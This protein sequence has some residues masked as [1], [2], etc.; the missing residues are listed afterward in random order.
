MPEMDG[1][2]TLKAMRKLEDYP[3][4]D[5]PVVIL[6]ANAI[7]GAREQYLQEGF[8]AFL[9]KPIDFEKLEKTVQ[10]LLDKELLHPVKKSVSSDEELRI[11]TS[12]LPMI[13]GLDWGYAS[14][15]FKEEEAMLKTVKHFAN[16]IEYDAKELETLYR[17]NEQDSD[18]KKYRTKVHS[19]KS[20]AAIV[21]IIPLAGMAKVLEDAARNNEHDVIEGMTPIF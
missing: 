8:Q 10:E 13:D 2:E 18:R 15:H 17:E 12:E 4:K 19:M 20:S 6:T 1:V 9:S 5:T 7:V 14:T 16:S 3:C 11:S 21:G